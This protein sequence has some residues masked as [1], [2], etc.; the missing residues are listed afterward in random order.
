MSRKLEK[1]IHVVGFYGSCK[2][3]S[4]TAIQCSV[5]ELTLS[6]EVNAIKWAR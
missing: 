4:V 3:F 5:A 6:F 1:S 2:G